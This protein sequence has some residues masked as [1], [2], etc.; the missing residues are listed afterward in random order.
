MFH[1]HLRKR[2]ILLHL[3][4]MSWRYQWDPSHL[5]YHLR[6]ASLL[7]FCFDDWSIGV[8]GLLK[9]PTLIVLLSF[10]PFV[11]LCLSYVLRCSYVGCTDIHNCYVFL[12]DWSLDHYAVSFLIS[13]NLY[14]KVYFS[15]MKITTSAFFCFPFAWNMF[16][17]SLTFIPYVSWGLK[18]VSYRQDIYVGLIFL[19]IQ[20]VFVFCLEHLIYWHLK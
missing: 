17:H 20:P 7:I 2:C 15:G 11:C 1:V 14:F 6:R 12:L 10:S 4:G 16:F 18:W 3:Y 13:C 19:S 8:S 9:S 5:V